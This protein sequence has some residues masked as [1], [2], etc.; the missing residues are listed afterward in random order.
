MGIGRQSLYDT[1]GDKRQI[2]GES[3]ERYLERM[4]EFLAA[5]LDVDDGL[6][7]VRDYMN[8]SVRDVM[9]PSPRRA[10]MMFNT[11]AELAPHDPE[12]RK[13]ARKGVLILQSTL[14]DE[15]RNGGPRVPTRMRTPWRS[16]SPPRSAVSQSCRRAA[17]PARSYRRQQMPQSMR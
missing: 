5:L 14:C 6:A 4:K 13:Q 9:S 1:F 2:F 8:A 10:C 15:R 3:L 17:P 12:I 16:S 11:C 7:A